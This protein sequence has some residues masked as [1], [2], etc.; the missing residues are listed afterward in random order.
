MRVT[1]SRL[2][3]I[4]DTKLA[5]FG[6][7]GGEEGRGGCVSQPGPL[8]SQTEVSVRGETVEIAESESRVVCLCKLLEI[9]CPCPSSDYGTPHLFANLQFIHS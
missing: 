9:N 4:C 3:A 2:P 1:V 8:G 6:L 7:S 5:L